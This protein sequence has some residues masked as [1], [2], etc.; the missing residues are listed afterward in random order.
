MTKESK[1]GPFRFVPHSGQLWNQNAEV[2][3]TPKSAAVLAMLLER[4]GQPV[5]KQE[6]FASIWRDTIVSDDALV[7]CI[8]E[9]RQ[10]LADDA[11]R[12]QYIETRHRMGYRFIAQVEQQSSAHVSTAPTQRTSTIAVLPFHDM[13]P[14]RDQDFFCEGLA[15]ELID[16]LTRVDGLR[17]IARS[18][19]FQF[20]SPGLDVR[21]VGRQLAADSLL[22]GSV[23]KAG[24]RL[25]ITVQLIDVESGVHKWSERF[26]AQLGD[27]FEIQDRIAAS[28]ATILRGASLTGNEKRSVRRPQT[29]TDSYEYFLR[30]RQHMHRVQQPDMDQSLEMF[31]TAIEL[32]SQYAPAWAGLAMAHGWLY[33]WWGARDENLREADR[34]S[35]IALQLAPDLAES[36]LARGFVLSLQSRYEEAQEQFE[37]AVTLNPQSFDTYYL[38]GRAAFARGDIERS[39][40]LF[41]KAAEVRPE[42]FQSAFLCGQS[43]RILGRTEEGKRW[44]EES[45]QRAERILALNPHD[46]RTLSLGGGALFAAGQPE[47]A[48]EWCERALKVDPDDVGA[49]INTACLHAKCENKDQA[50]AILERVFGRGFGKR[51]WI[52]SDPDYDCLRDDPRFIAMLEKLK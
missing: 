51:G 17:V 12:P 39:A 43:L 35:H 28:V 16:A 27:V 6:L 38:Y 5:S 14:G 37:A 22:E 1:F 19:S 20:R 32:D 2:R 41:G 46:V 9:L 11:R 29:A 52:E 33:E 25:R 4:A 48:F 40:E 23:R 13:S 26:D 3:L 49:L 31:R 30:G 45:I 10:A 21:E 36:H 15:E 42:D 44:N 24:D 8:Q 47:R 50:I 7:S 18:A 34:A